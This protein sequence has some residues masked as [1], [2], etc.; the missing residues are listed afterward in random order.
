MSKVS[1][2]K[3]K[4]LNQ[5]RLEIM[6]ISHYKSGSCFKLIFLYR[7]T[8]RQIKV[9]RSHSHPDCDY[10]TSLPQMRLTFGH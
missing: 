7:Q 10:K 5:K 3:K 9:E 4:K 2:D 8:D 1:G 6:K